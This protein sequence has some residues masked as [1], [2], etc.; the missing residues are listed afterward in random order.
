MVECQKVGYA[1]IFFAVWW[2]V[3]QGDSRPGGRAQGVPA[4]AA[5][6]VATV[7]A[8]KGMDIGQIV[9]KS[10][11]GLRRVYTEIEKIKKGA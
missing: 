10:S 4:G 11:G 1:E 2:Q 9:R 3:Q 5:R 6:V 7:N 8:P